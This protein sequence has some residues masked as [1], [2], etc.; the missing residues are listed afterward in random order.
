MLDGW[1]NLP[2][3]FRKVG[4]KLTDVLDSTLLQGNFSTKEMRAVWQ[5]QNKIAQQLKIEA[6]LSKAEGQLGVIPEAAAEKIVK[7]ATLKN[8]DIP[9][10]ARQSAEKRH[11][12]IALIN[13]LQ[14][15]AGE[16][17]GEFVHYGATTQDIVD[18]GTMLQT[19]QAYELL[20]RHGRQL[21]HTLRRQTDRYRHTLMIGRTHGIQAIPITFGFKLA[22]WLDE[23]LRDQRRLTD[24]KDNGV[25][26]GSLNGA[27]GTYA[28]FGIQGPEIERRALTDVGLDVPNISW[29]PA[30][31]RFS[32]FATALGIYSGTLGKIG[33]ELFNLMKTEVNKICEPFKKGEIGS[34]TMPQ[35]RNPALIEGL[36]SL[37]QPVFKDIGLMLESMLIDGERDAIHWRNEWVVLPEITNYLDAQ[38]QNA[39]YILSDLQVNETKMHENLELQHGLPFAE[40]IM[41]QL[42]TAVGKQTAHRLVYNSAMTAIEQHQN[43]IEVLYAENEVKQHFSKEDLIS[44]TDPEKDIGSIQEKIELVLKEAD[45][46]LD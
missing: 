24:L 3:G 6:A 38:L 37:T 4:K 34:S 17:A 32:E 36:A 14:E 5:D 39:S 19:K 35:K 26:V 46:I 30:R 21:I 13:R 29:Q 15:L 43:F 1:Q 20:E 41:F 28:A 25:F 23:L 2:N 11:S 45:K 7:S 40:R 18:T 9:E 10:L 27:V 16:T 33:H 8:F 12:L 22:I 42:G 31:D 44:W